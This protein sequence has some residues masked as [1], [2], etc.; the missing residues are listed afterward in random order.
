MLTDLHIH[1]LISPD[2]DTALTDMALAAAGRGVGCLCF[3]D[4]CDLDD[5]RTGTPDP[6]CFDR[7][8]D[9]MYRQFLDAKPYLSELGIDVRLGIELGEMTHDPDRAADIAA[10]PELDF[11][12][13]SLHNLRNT[14]DFYDLTYESAE[15]CR[16]LLHKYM[17]E[18]V[19]LARFGHFDSMAHI[20]YA[21]RYMYNAG[22]DTALDLDHHGDE[23]ETLFSVLIQSG[24]GIELNCSG[25]RHPGIAGPIPTGEILSLYR[26]MGGEIITVGGDAHSTSEAGTCIAEG[27]E[28]LRSLGF[29]YVSTFRNRR[30]EMIRI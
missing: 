19:E 29:R 1:T 22:F 5:Y 4:H 23:L 2:S 9:D 21:R 11:V 13:G 10:E 14:K 7:I 26:S 16:D 3:T 25:F 20:G 17:E 30:M 27:F 24:L 15:Q 6:E 28:L 18:L 12:L 8:R